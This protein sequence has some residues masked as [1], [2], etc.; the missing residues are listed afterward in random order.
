MLDYCTRKKTKEGG[1]GMDYEETEP[2]LKTG[3]VDGVNGNYYVGPRAC[4][5]RPPGAIT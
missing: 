1:S 5:G 2:E 4:T 3:R